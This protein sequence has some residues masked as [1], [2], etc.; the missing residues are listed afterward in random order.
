MMGDRRG[1]AMMAAR[2]RIRGRAITVRL[3]IRLPQYS[4]NRRRRRRHR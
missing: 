4:G 3:L 1:G 2:A